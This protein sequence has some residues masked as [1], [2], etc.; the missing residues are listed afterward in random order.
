MDS[1]SSL[2]PPPPPYIKFFT[3][4]NLQKLK[5]WKEHTSGLDGAENVE[6][7]PKDE[8]N[9]LIPP[10]LPAGN[11][12]R[13]FGNLWQI[14]DKIPKLKDMG[15]TQLYPSSD[16]ISQDVTNEDPITHEST[17]T[18]T[19][20]TTD[21]AKIDPK[22]NPEPGEELSSFERIQQ[23]NKLLKSLLLNFLELIGIMGVSPEQFPN[24]LENIHTILL[25]FHHLLNEYRPHQSRESLI[26]LLTKQIESKKVEI[27]KIND[28]CEEVKERISKLTDSF[29]TITNELEIDDDDDVKM[30]DSIKGDKENELQV[31]KNDNDNA[32]N[33]RK[34]LKDMKIKEKIVWE[35]LEEELNK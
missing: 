24:K 18:T 20:T 25:N 29:E 15:V 34:R 32:I 14:N 12:Y 10:P 26:L 8:L 4:E 35:L 31:H 33:L 9:F 7:D 30:E 22:T 13:S 1:L 17:T 19:I 2:Y 3:D 16:S 28:C 21:P 5:E 27:L 6:L 23:L 11:T